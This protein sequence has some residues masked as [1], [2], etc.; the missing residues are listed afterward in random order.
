MLF[1]SDWVKKNS[2]IEEREIETA[3]KLARFGIKLERVGSYDGTSIMN[4]CFVWTKNQKNEVVTLSLSDYDSLAVLY[5]K[6]VALQIPAAVSEKSGDSVKLG[7]QKEWEIIAGESSDT[8]YCNLAL[9]EKCVV[10]NKGGTGCLDSGR[11]QQECSS[12]K[13]SG[14]I[15]VS[16][17][18]TSK[19]MYGLTS[20]R[21]QLACVQE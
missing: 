4:Y 11:P 7:G 16:L 14:R 13:Q 9:L 15:P 5:P 1:R 21:E 18:A 10:T 20:P 3:S 19:C 8:L 6:K 2:K 12:E 17:K